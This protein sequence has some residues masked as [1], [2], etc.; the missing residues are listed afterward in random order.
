MRQRWTRPVPALT[1]LPDA[2]AQMVRA[3][4]PD[5]RVTGFAALDGGLANT[6]LRVELESGRVLLR[7]YQRDPS[8]AR[9]EAAL[10]RRL[11]GIVP[12]PRVLHLG[13]HDGQ[14]FALLYWM[15]GERLELALDDA[16]AHETL[17]RTAG[18]ALARIHSVIFENAGLLDGDL[19]VATPV[20]VDKAWLQHFLRATLIDGGGARFVPRDLAEAVIAFAERHGDARWPGPYCLAH[21]DYNG[22]NIL[23]RDGRVSA[24]LDWEFAFA[25][26]PAQDFGNLL[27]NHPQAAFIEAVLGG[28]R[29]AGGCVPDDWRRLAMTADLASW[30][31]FLT[32]PVVD[33]TLAEDALAA[34]HATIAL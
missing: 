24:V 26:T 13:A 21:C 2:V 32:R 28:Y 4:L 25:G 10:A 34:L 9:K 12:V 7:L 16:A 18:Q 20:L 19:H 17:G 3:G 27:R 5:A 30:A 15:E 14:T 33:P 29:D 23:V 8:Q 11:D 1:P 6:N 31:D 22:S